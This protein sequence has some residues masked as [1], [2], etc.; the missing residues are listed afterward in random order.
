M[1]ISYRGV[2]H[3]RNKLMLERKWALKHCVIS[4]PC[5]IH[6]AIMCFQPLYYKLRLVIN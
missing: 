1:T 4:S 6:L 5:A 3:Y 2:F